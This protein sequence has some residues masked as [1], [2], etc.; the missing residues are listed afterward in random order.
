MKK[1]TP[2]YEKKRFITF[3]NETMETSIESL[4]DEQLGELMRI[5]YFYDR[6][7]EEPESFSSDAVKVLFKVI[8]RELDYKLEKYRDR[9][10]K[11]KKASDIRWGKE[12][13]PLKSTPK[14]ANEHQS[15]AEKIDEQT[16][17]LKQDI[18]EL[19][20]EHNYD[21][22]EE[23][24]RQV[25]DYFLVQ[26]AYTFNKTH[27]D[28]SKASLDR[29]IIPKLSGCDDNGA[30][31]EIFQI[32]GD[33]K[34]LETYKGIIDLYFKTSFAE[35]CDYSI[36]HFLSGEIRTLKY[37]EYLREPVYYDDEEA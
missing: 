4:S 6:Y 11:S 24:A 22:D 10:E 12:N 16:E 25:L 21:I 2:R 5:S 30:S 9:C 18:S 33:D 26:Y 1:R 35:G 15:L 34:D 13:N 36:H 19:Y 14:K 20:K 31:G 29:L 37:R 3:E 28:I 8:K 27:P 32:Y 23:L 7:R 17:Q